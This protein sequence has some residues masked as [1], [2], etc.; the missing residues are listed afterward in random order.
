M[1]MFIKNKA[2]FNCDMLFKVCNQSIYF[3]LMFQFVQITVSLQ[4][5]NAPGINLHVIL[6]VSQNYHNLYKYHDLLIK[7]ILIVI[8]Q[9]SKQ[10]SI[11]Y[12]WRLE[13][14]KCIYANRNTHL[15]MN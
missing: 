12:F 3:K 5:V 11:I 7:Y 10:S 1:Y 13:K 2:A 8:S 6:I 15:S 4:T 14:Y 9:Y